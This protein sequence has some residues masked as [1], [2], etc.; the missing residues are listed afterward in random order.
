ME[1]IAKNPIKKLIF[2]FSI[3]IL[4]G[5]FLFIY[6]CNT[7]Q[8]LLAK[9]DKKADMREMRNNNYDIMNT[10][11]EI[12]KQNQIIIEWQKKHP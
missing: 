12:K 9:V 8:I 5:I 1:E 7:R 11:S 2:D 3:M 10:L 4:I 6:S